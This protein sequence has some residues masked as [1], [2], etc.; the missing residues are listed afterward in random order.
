MSSDKLAKSFKTGATGTSS[1][2]FPVL[3]GATRRAFMFPCLRQQIKYDQG[4]HLTEEAM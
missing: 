3:P 1:L 4:Q 2:F